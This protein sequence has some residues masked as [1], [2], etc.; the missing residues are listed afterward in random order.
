MKFAESWNGSPGLRKLIGLVEKRKCVCRLE[1]V[2]RQKRRT[3]NVEADGQ[4][5]FTRLP[6][7]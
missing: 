1:P 7:H 2:Q 5:K 4:V 6:V 3:S